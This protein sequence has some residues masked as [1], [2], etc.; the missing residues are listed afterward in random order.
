MT[1]LET[2]RN[3]TKEKEALMH[4]YPRLGEREKIVSARASK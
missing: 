2:K 1:A 3:E 4:R